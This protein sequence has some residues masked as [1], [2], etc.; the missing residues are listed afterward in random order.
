MEAVRTCIGCRE[1]EARK[2]LIRLVLVGNNLELDPKKS[3]PGRG[4]WL[5]AKRGCLKLALDR[6]AFSRALKRE[7]KANESALTLEIDKAETMLASN[8]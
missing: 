1:R 7:F 3:L 5:H 6:K 4:A 2:T 8:E